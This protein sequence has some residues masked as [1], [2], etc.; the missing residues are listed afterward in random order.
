MGQRHRQTKQVEFTIALGSDLIEDG[1]FAVD[2]RVRS[3]VVASE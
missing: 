1:L 2:F 3:L